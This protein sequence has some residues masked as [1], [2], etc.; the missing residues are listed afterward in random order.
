MFPHPIPHLGVG[1]AG[2]HLQSNMIVCFA[3][4]ISPGERELTQAWIKAGQM[5]E[6]P[7]SHAEGLDFAP[8]AL[9]GGS[10]HT[11]YRECSGRNGLNTGVP[12]KG[13]NYLK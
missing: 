11:E 6:R 7:T 8:K 3:Q 13:S 12:Y 10:R 4:S 9:Y 1:G 2:G 5:R